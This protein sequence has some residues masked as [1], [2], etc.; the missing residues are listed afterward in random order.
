[1]AAGVSTVCVYAVAGLGE[2]GQGG[3]THDAL[4]GCQAVAG[5]PPN[6]AP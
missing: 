1:M 3:E 5:A 2:S 4:L 6:P